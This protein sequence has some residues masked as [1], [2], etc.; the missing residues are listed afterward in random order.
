MTRPDQDGRW[1]IG[2]F[3]AGGVGGLGEGIAATRHLLLAPDPSRDLLLV[4]MSLVAALA[5]STVA[6]ALLPWLARR[7]GLDWPVGRW[8]G[9]VCGATGWTMLCCAAFLPGWLCLLSLL[10]LCL[11]PSFVRKPVGRARMIVSLC[12]LAAL[13]V[14]VADDRRPRDRDAPPTDPGPD[15]VVVV[16]DGLRADQL[17]RTPKGDLLAMPQ[18]TALAAKGSSF[19]RAVAPVTTTEA[20]REAVISG[21]PP[22]TVAPR[23]GWADELTDVGWR[24]AIFGG[25]EVDRV[26]RNT[27]FGV[28]DLDPGWL[29][30][31]SAAAP[32]RLWLR[33]VGEGRTRRSGRRMVQSWSHWLASLPADRPAV[34]V[35]H[36][37][38]LTWPTDPAP[39]W[40]TA[41]QGPSANAGVDAEPVGRCGAVA[42]QQGQPTRAAVRAAYDGAAASVD[43]LLPDIWS[44]ASARPRGAM[45]FVVGARGTPLGE[46]DR[47]LAAAG[48]LH[49][50]DARVVLVAF[51]E[52][53]PEGSAL[54]VPVSTVDVVA[55]I[56]ARTGLAPL[57]DARPIPGLVR[58]YP[59]R[60]VAYAVGPSATVL[61]VSSTELVRRGADGTVARYEEA[62]WVQTDAGAARSVPVLP[63]VPAE[64]D[65]CAR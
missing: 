6:G 55:S 2:A 42:T 51:G 14:R 15:L 31:A 32:G 4:G 12:F 60:D 24:T 44:M 23:R 59:P 8:T 30:G 1:W 57:A 48:A 39:P 36:F 63:A 61:A 58:G 9:F 34:S 26:A 62:R 52:E 29:S 50:A 21:V 45:V 53:I 16:V 43:A 64:A 5:V 22:W 46:E 54:G 38:D 19:T 40:D 25:P 11:L 65:V 13:A 7:M 28:V 18:L 37:A 10:L 47:W 35:L 56:R 20:A 41:F 33:M 17:D 27:G 3:I 49:P